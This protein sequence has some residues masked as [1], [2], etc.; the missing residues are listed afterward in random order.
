MFGQSP[1]RRRS[2]RRSLSPSSTA[3][4]CA[5]ASSCTT[6]AGVRIY[7]HKW[8]WMWTKEWA[9]SLAWL[10]DGEV[11]ARVRRRRAVRVDGATEDCEARGICRTFE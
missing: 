10:A 4:S 7:W 11:R 3:S 5:T 8:E 1:S 6:K 9:A 2:E